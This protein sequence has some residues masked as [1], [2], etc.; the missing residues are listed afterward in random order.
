M[1]T[2]ATSKMK[3]K[4]NGN[5]KKESNEKEPKKKTKLHFLLNDL[6]WFL[7]YVF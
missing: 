3:K 4:E 7:D 1:M 2:M 5:E 6:T